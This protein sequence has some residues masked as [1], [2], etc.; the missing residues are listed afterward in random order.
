MYFYLNKVWMYRNK[1]MQI[2]LICALFT[3]KE[4]SLP[5]L[6]LFAWIYLFLGEIINQ[7]V[8]TIFRDQVTSFTWTAAVF[9]WWKFIKQYIPYLSAFVCML[10]L[11][12]KVYFIKFTI[13]VCY[14]ACII[15]VCVCVFVVKLCNPIKWLQV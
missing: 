13:Y 6:L 3:L 14:T 10:H 15:R 4:H 12:L 8:I 5:N 9:R 1:F 7:K 11:N 2:F